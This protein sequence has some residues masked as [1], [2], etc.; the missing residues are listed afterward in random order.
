MLGWLAQAGG[1]SRRPK[2]IHWTLQSSGLLLFN[3]LQPQ[4]CLTFTSLPI[5]KY[6][7]H[8]SS[9]QENNTTH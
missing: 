6:S 9:A 2:R 3:D 5:K 1:L 8:T 4:P 7:F